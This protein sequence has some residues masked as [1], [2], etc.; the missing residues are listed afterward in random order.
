MIRQEIQTGSM[1]L[2][3]W[4]E[5][6]RISRPGFYQM[7]KAGTAPLTYHCGRR[8]FVSVEADREWLAQREQAAA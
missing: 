4:C 6:R 2:A 7:L 3:E 8:R 1:T 5:Y